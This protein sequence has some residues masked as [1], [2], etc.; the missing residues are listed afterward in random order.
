MLAFPVRMIGFEGSHP[1]GCDAVLGLFP[2]LTAFFSS[3]EKHAK[4][5][6]RN[7]SVG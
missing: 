5:D 2:E 4:T 7:I 6:A 1:G 3:A